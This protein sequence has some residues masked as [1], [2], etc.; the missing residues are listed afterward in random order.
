[1]S[2]NLLTDDQTEPNY[3]LSFVQQ[4]AFSLLQLY[5]PVLWQRRLQ[6]ALPL[7]PSREAFCFTEHGFSISITTLT[8]LAETTSE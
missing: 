8:E 6:L 1:M 2:I 7:R 5:L 4:L 3:I